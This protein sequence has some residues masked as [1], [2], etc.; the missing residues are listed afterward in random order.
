MNEKS[1]KDRLKNIAE[2]ENATF[3]EILKRLELER[4]LMRLS[5]SECGSRYIF[6]GGLLL[7]WYIDI[8]RETKD[9]DFLATRMTAD[10]VNIENDM[11]QVCAVVVDDGFMFSFGDITPLEQPHMNY[12]GFRVNIDLRIYENMRDRIQLDIGVGDAV[13]PESETFPLTRYR[14]SSLFE[15]SISLQVYPLEAIFAEKLETIIS[16]GAAN[17]RMKDYHDLY[18]LVKSERMND[19]KVISSISATFKNRGTSFN[20]PVSFNDSDLAL[21]QKQWA[22]HY[23]GLGNMSKEMDLPDLIR[24]V[25][26]VI[27][28]YV[29]GKTTLKR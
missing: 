13:I 15:K 16:K 11:K 6:K 10:I 9:I 4:Y 24:E 27:N 3:G 21:L 8:G 2:A 20:T 18:C 19:E 23:R 1:L 22:A 7:S 28:T 12:P 5:R 25:I 14:E 17:S 26:D 29:T